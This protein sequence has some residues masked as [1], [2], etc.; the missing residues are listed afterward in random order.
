MSR[1]WEK[2]KYTHTSNG[3]LF[4]LHASGNLVKIITTT[5]M[6]QIFFFLSVSQCR[7]F[8]PVFVLLLKRLG[9]IFFFEVNGYY[10][11][12]HCWHHICIERAKS[13]RIPMR[14]RSGGDKKKVSHFFEITCF[15]VTTRIVE[16]RMPAWWK[17]NSK[18][19]FNEHSI[20]KVFFL[21][22]KIKLVE[23]E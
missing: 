4:I 15:H 14:D 10:N 17:R 11:K 16:Q 13:V 22:L 20:H 19:K 7:V 1:G 9:N 5:K 8:F 18:K 3:I 21:S 2:N 12:R 23:N 6:F